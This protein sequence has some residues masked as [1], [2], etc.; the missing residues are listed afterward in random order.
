VGLRDE[1]GETHFSPP[2]LRGLSQAGPYF[3]DNRAT[4][5]EEVFTR[6]NHRLPEKLSDAELQ[7]LLHFLNGL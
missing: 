4:T 2:S 6:F 5:V 7:D 1:A 3:H